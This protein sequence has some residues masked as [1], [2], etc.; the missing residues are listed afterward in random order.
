MSRSERPP[1][2]R[3]LGGLSLTVSVEGYGGGDTHPPIHRNGTGDTDEQRW[4]LVQQCYVRRY[5]YWTFLN[6]CC[7]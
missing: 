4:F 6:E 7:D 1:N 3:K 5:P 2:Q